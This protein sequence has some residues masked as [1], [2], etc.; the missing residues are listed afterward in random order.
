MEDYNLHPVLEEC[1]KAARTGF[2]IASEQEKHL[3]SALSS[4]EEKVRDT[5]YDFNSSPC[6]SPEAT[7]LLEGQLS[8]IEQ[9]FL[10]LSFAFK[11]DLENLRGNLNKFSITLFVVYLNH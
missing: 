11:E 1:K 9:A 2:N 3:N 6:Y 10:R 7:S 8:D 5:L 4:A